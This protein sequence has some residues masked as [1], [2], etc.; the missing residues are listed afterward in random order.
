MQKKLLLLPCLLLIS[1]LA[2]AAC[3]GGGDSDESQ[4]E[5]AIET[6]V[7]SSDP[8]DCTKLETQNF[9]EQ[10]NDGDGAE[11]LKE[12]EAD[13][14]DESDKADSVSVSEV[15]VDGTDAT[16]EAKFSGSTLDG[17]TVEVALVKDGDQWKLNEVVGFAELDK[18]ALVEAIETSFEDEDT[19][20]EIASCIGEAFEAAEQ[21]EIEESIFGG[22][23]GALVELYEEC[24]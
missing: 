24:S 22:S 3:G 21:S 20:S 18:K 6:S 17:Q 23:S 10:G 14:E 16:A 15:E 7:T 1:A 4:I 11:A 13:A 2:L 12:C 8:A 19:S 5:D 9:I